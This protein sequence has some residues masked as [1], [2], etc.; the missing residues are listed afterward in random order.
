[1]L[2]SVVPSSVSVQPR[3]ALMVV[4][5]VTKEQAEEIAVQ[6]AAAALASV[7]VV[8]ADGFELV[9][10]ERAPP[11]DA[12]KE[13]Q[14]KSDDV[15]ATPRGKTEPP[16][17]LPPG[18]KTVEQWGKTHV[19]WGKRF[20]GKSYVSAASNK[21]YVEWIKDHV[22]SCGPAVHDFVAYLK[23]ANIIRSSSS[24]AD[25]HIPG[26]SIQRKFAD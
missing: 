7:I 12:A 21:S 8:D 13:S 15:V 26:T 20:K 16:V 23:A 14:K 3:S 11:C 18:V 9:A 1:V 6:A 24:S 2:K 10:Q 4:V 25:D 5:C 17:E 19:V 22:N